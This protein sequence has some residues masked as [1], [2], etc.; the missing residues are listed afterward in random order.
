MWTLKFRAKEEW[1]LYN[2]RTVKFNVKLQFY[3]RNYYIKGKKI[4][5]VNSGIVFGEEKNKK[6]F[7]LDL[8]KDKKIKELETNNDFFISIYC[9]TATSERGEA[10]KAVYNEKLT[11]LKPVVFDSEGWEWWEVSSFDREDLEEIIKQAEKLKSVNF[12]LFFLKEQ[13]IKD[14]MIYSTMPDLTDKQKKVFNLAVSSGYYGY[15][16][17]SKLADLA[18]KVGLSLSTFQFHLAKAEGKLMPFFSKKL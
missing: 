6:D 12:E 10:L 5:F 1:N 3:S 18:K 13:K 9:E 15:P 4:Y 17:K 8:K 14:L 7:F 2:S 11:F 16:R